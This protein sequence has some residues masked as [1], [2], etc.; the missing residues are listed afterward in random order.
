MNEKLS[1]DGCEGELLWFPV[2]N[3][4]LIKIPQDGLEARADNGGH[5]EGVSDFGAASISLSSSAHV[6]A[7]AVDGGN[8]GKC[9]G[10]FTG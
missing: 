9:G 5:V 8:S 7:I 10:L 4:F 3:E 1:H 2:F 6:S